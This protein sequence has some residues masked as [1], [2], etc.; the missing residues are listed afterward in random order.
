MC[1]RSVAVAVLGALILLPALAGAG[2]RVALLPISVHASGSD[3][4]YL[5]KGLAEMISARLEQYQGLVVVRPGGD[6]APASGRDQAFERGRESGADFVLYGSFTRFGEG[7]SLDLRCEQI[8]PP[9]QSPVEQEEQ[10]AASARRVFIQAGTLAEIIPN[11][12][13]LAEKVARFAISSPSV[14]RVQD[15]GAN[16]AGNGAPPSGVSKAEVEG[17]MRRLDA[18]EGAVYAP[19][20]QGEAGPE[21]D[22]TAAASSVVR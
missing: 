7:A 16:A 6:A 10:A 15:G 5:Q 13:T 20:A 14:A 2:A 19:V 18:L 3:S 17:I 22:G 1:T 11:L 21:A 8:P 9:G 4:E 12:D